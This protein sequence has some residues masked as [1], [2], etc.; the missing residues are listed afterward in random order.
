[1]VMPFLY[2]IT[3]MVSLS[4]NGDAISIFNHTDGQFEL[5]W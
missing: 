5:Q 1:M 3:L 2:L 4:Y